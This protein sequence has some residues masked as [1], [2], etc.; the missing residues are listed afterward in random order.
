MC[1][2]RFMSGQ[3]AGSREAMAD[4]AGEVG[5]LLGDCEETRAALHIE[6]DSQHKDL[7]SKRSIAAWAR[8]ISVESKWVKQ[9][10]PYSWPDSRY[11]VAVPIFM[12]YAQLTGR[13]LVI[14]QPAVGYDDHFFCDALRRAPSEADAPDGQPSARIRAPSAS[15]GPLRDVG[16]SRWMCVGRR[17]HCGWP[18]AL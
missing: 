8:S 14:L 11:P 12:L 5:N 7:Y 6:A 17:S 2:A 9:N 4:F 1:W 18:L 13:S 3:A 16:V 15:E 10:A